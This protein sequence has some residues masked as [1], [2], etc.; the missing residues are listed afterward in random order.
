MNEKNINAPVNNQA[1]LSLVFGILTILFFCIGMIPIPFTGF[2]CF[3][4]SLLFGILTLVFG[5]ISL[6]RIRSQKEAGGTMAW[7]SLILV[8]IVFLCAICMVVS[9]ASLFILAPNLIH[10]PSSLPSFST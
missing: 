7:T 6:N 8:G 5:F 9:M 10:W 1:I 2:I 4:S 3:P